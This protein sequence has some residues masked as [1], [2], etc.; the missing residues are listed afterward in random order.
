MNLVL[1]SVEEFGKSMDDEMLAAAL[2]YRGIKKGRPEDIK[3]ANELAERDVY[4]GSYFTPALYFKYKKYL[5]EKA[6]ENLLDDLRLSVAPGAWLRTTRQGYGNVNIPMKGAQNC[7][8]AGEA[9]GN[10]GIY[11]DA[12]N[13]GMKLLQDLLDIV[14][15]AGSIPEYNSPVYTAVSIAPLASIANFAKNKEAVLKAR[16]LQE[17][18]FIDLCSRYHEPTNQI[19]GPYSRDYM[20]TRCGATGGTKMLL[21]K[22]LPQ[23]LFSS[24]EPS[25]Q[26]F[27]NCPESQYALTGSREAGWIASLDYS[28]PEYMN[29]LAVEKKFP[30]EVHGTGRCGPLT[31][32]NDSDAGGRY[33]TTCYM[34]REY[35]LASASRS[36]AMHGQS[37]GTVL[38]WRKRSP[39]QSMKDF[40][41]MIWLY[42]EDEKVLGDL[43]TFPGISNRYW[44]LDEGHWHSVQN[45]NK[46]I[47]LYQPMKLGNSHSKLRLSCFVP[48]Y[49]QVD[50]L[51]VGDIKV[52]KFPYY[53]SHK[54][55]IFIKDGNTFVALRFLAP[56]RI[57]G[58]NEV[59]VEMVEEASHPKMMVISSWNFE[60]KE[61]SFSGEEMDLVRNGFVLEVADTKDFAS[62]EAFKEHIKCANLEEVVYANGVWAVK[63]VSGK[64]DLS[65][66]Y[67]LALHEIIERKVNG[68]D[69]V[70]PIF[71]SPLVK[72]DRTGHIEI[73]KTVLDTRFGLPVWLMADEKHG[74]YMVMNLNNQPI[75][76]S[77]K[78]PDGE[79]T[80]DALPLGRIIYQPRLEKTLDILSAQG[81]SPIKFTAKVNPQQV[82][83]N[84]VYVSNESL[85]KENLNWVYVGF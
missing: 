54:E 38:W 19:S 8:L 22:M 68:K 46:V 14:N 85:K 72:A 3:K 7:I 48:I 31:W 52:D 70:A 15:D 26:W 28:Y 73:G 65:I 6:R 75:P 64:E 81:L 79:L 77:L 67:N 47:T 69:V 13:H 59:V 34:T 50:E 20:P 55:T 58:E 53:L 4:G 71:L 35:T 39:I 61:R 25:Y 43:N 56:T 1:D 24:F 74:V 5:T 12:F 40:K 60:G 21:Y 16:L 18:I 17:V 83:V 42:V 49:D 57:E 80:T 66:V 2:I 9:L 78:T 44:L 10:V 33:D 45:K 29:I 27:R 23:G 63:Y 84:D 37:H 82:L 36:P 30:Y 32:S 76:V 41:T 51:W 62:L 11:N